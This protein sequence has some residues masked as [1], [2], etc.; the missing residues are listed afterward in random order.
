MN[1]A[2]WIILAIVVVWIG[3]AIKVAFF[4]GFGKKGRSCHGAHRDVD[5]PSDEDLKLPNACMGCSKGS[6]SGCAS[7]TDRHD[8]PIP[9]IREEPEP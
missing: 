5:L 8:I 2:S 6:C 3:I 7:A 9:I 4:G 1:I